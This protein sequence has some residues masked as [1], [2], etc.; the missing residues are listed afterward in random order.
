MYYGP[1][2]ASPYD[3]LM[4]T[5]DLIKLRTRILIQT[6]FLYQMIFSI[7]LTF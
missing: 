1:A 6:K 2:Y 3:R 7:G 4:N 5:N